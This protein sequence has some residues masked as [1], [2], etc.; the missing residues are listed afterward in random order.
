MASISISIWSKA[1][2]SARQ[3]ATNAVKLGESV[4]NFSGQLEHADKLTL[5]VA[6]VSTLVLET[7]KYIESVGE[8]LNTVNMARAVISGTRALCSAV[9]VLTLRIF[10]K[11]KDGDQWVRREWLI[12]TLNTILVISRFFNFTLWMDRLKAID[13]G[14]HAEWV[15]GVVMTGFAAVGIL[16]IAHSG[17]NLYDDWHNHEREGF[18]KVRVAQFLQACAELLESVPIAMGLDPNLNIAVCIFGLVSGTFYFA[19]ELVEIYY[20]PAS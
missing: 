10:F 13:L 18:I 20:T 1:Q 7:S 5:L 6:S 4:S 14:K 15:G 9:E 2:D 19:K 12:C 11:T 3:T 8:L 17:Q 16:S